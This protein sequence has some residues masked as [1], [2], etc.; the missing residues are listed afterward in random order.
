MS[1][2]NEN[3]YFSDSTLFATLI[4]KFLGIKGDLIALSEDESL[5]NP[6]LTGLKEVIVNAFRK[7]PESYCMLFTKTRLIVED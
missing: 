4:F 3:F 2:S 7:D 1:F 5:E 6:R